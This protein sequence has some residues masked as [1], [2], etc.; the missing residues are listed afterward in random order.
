MY[1]DGVC[2]GIGEETGM[3]RFVYWLVCL[4]SVKCFMN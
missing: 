3:V 1:D 2:G 4:W